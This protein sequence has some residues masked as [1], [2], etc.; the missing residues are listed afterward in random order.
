MPVRTLPPRPSLEN[1]RKQAKGLLKAFKARQPEALSRIK[2]SHPIHSQ[3]GTAAILAAGVTLQDAQ[4]VIAVEYGFRG[5]P[6]LVEALKSSVDRVG[7]TRAAVE[8]DDVSAL[9]RLLQEDPAIVDER[10]EWVDRK[11]RSRQTT[12]FRYAHMRG[13]TASM[14]LLQGA[15]ADSG[16]LNNMLWCNAYNLNLPQIERLLTLGV[17]LNTTDALLAAISSLWVFDVGRRHACI[18]TLVESGA[19]FEDGPVMDIHRGHLETLEGRLRRDPSL[20]DGLYSYQLIAGYGLSTVE[21]L[22]LLHIAAAHNET[23]C[24]ALLLRHGADIDAKA[25]ILSDDSGGQTPVYHAIGTSRGACYDVFEFLVG[26]GPDLTARAHLH[27]VHTRGS[28]GLLG[29]TRPHEGEI[30][31]FTP[32]GYASARL[33]FYSRQHPVRRQ[34]AREVERLRHLGAPE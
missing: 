22:P 24:A 25:R 3:S 15:G 8:R 29:V 18:N 20:I 34:T 23:E 27:G 13:A 19:A 14:A 5:W 10:F 30:R 9:K 21:G 12:P 31:Q 7:L 16:F 26:E 1:L 33:E 32:L 6:H 17:D 2:Q 4:A 28:L 11:G